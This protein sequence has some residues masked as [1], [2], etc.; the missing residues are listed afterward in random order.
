MCECGGCRGGPSLDSE[1]GRADQRAVG[2]EC[3]DVVRCAGHHVAGGCGG[4]G[5]PVVH[6]DVRRHSGAD[7]RQQPGPVERPHGDG[8]VPVVEPVVER[9]GVCS[10]DAGRAGGVHDV[11]GH[12]QRAVVACE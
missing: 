11:P 8:P 10:G 12:R 9:S 4:V 1:C 3:D 6:A 7:R 5:Q 2:S